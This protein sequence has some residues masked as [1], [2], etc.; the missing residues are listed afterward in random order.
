METIDTPIP[1]EH[2]PTA[3][4]ALIER[5]V[6]DAGLLAERRELRSYPGAAH[7][8]IR[9]PGTQGTL[10]LTYWPQAERLWFAVHANRRAD[11]IAPA[12]AELRARIMQVCDGSQGQGAWAS[13]CAAPHSSI[14][15]G[16]FGDPVAEY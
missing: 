15:T 9:R 14:T 2:S 1:A 4:I 10:E 7:W 11:W 16:V 3:L 6:S 12:M 13:E 8:H 5:A